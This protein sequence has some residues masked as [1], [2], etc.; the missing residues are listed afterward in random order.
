MNNPRS[1]CRA[2]LRRPLPPSHCNATTA[3]R[4]VTSHC[5]FNTPH[6][7]AGLCELKVSDG[8]ATVDAQRVQSLKGIELNEFLLYHGAAHDKI[9]TLQKQGLDPRR[10]GT[11]RGKMFGVGTYLAAH[12]SK[13]DIYAAANAAGERCI[14]VVRACL[15]EPHKVKNY[16]ENMRNWSMPPERTDG[17]GPFSSVVALTLAEGGP[18]RHPEYVVYKDS[19]TLPEYAIHY[20]HAP[21]CKCVGCGYI[22]LSF[23]KTTEDGALLPGFTVHAHSLDTVAAVSTA[24]AA[25]GH[26]ASYSITQCDALL[27]PSSTLDQLGIVSGTELVARRLRVSVSVRGQDGSLVYFKI[28][29]DSSLKKMMAVYARHPGR[30]ASEYRFVFR[31]RDVLDTQTPDDLGM[32]EDDVID[33]MSEALHPGAPSRAPSRSAIAV[34]YYT[35]K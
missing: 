5:L 15:G 6:A 17:R 16:E 32:K 9:D 18:V 29:R 28:R 22:R 3:D 27:D 10:G 12:S 2:P 33:A 4:T 20:K 26:D 11:N 30:S 13:S 21:D 8:L 23:R 25:A 14:L 34:T 24:A 35:I 7:V 19:H 31:G 1:H